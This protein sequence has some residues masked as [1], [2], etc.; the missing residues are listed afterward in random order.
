MKSKSRVFLHFFQASLHIA[1]VI[2]FAQHTLN[3]VIINNKQKHKF[4][5]DFI[6]QK[7][8]RELPKLSYHYKRL[9]VSVRGYESSHMQRLY[10]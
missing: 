9:V 7:I 4:F 2:T 10:A 3:E 8:V 6:K 5:V 1:I